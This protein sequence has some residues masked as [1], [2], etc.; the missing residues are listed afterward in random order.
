MFLLIF[1]AICIGITLGLLGSGGSIITLP[2]LIYFGGLD[3][4]VAIASS[5]LIVG[6]I[7]LAASVRNIF[8]RKVEFSAVINFGLTSMLGSYIS[9]WLSQGVSAK[10]QLLTFS[11][12]M[13]FAAYRMLR[14]SQSQPE[15]PSKIKVAMMGYLVGMVTG[16]VGVGGGFLIVPALVVF[17]GLTIKRAAST[18]LVIIA[19]QS[20]AGFAKHVTVLD[21][22][23]LNLDWNVIVTMSVVGIIGSQVGTYFNDKISQQALKKGFGVFLLFMALYIVVKSV[24]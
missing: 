24:L 11:I 17:T 5:L 7:S 3:E 22:L 15:T 6:F 2:V 8:E 10:V 20:F 19:L 9:A 13:L 4:K 16:F 1:G 18:S 21:S 23:G 14:P 12:V